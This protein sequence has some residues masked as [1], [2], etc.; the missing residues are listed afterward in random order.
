M[1]GNLKIHAH[2]IVSKIGECLPFPFLRALAHTLAMTSSLHTP[3]VTVIARSGSDVAIST[4][5][6]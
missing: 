4:A 5:K 6:K 2:S 1:T 3:L